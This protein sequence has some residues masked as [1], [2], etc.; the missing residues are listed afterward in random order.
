MFMFRLE[1]PAHWSDEAVDLMVSWLNDKD[2]MKYSEQR[3]QSHSH[4]SQRRYLK[5]IVARDDRFWGIYVDNALVGTVSASMD[6]PN[7][8]ANLGILRGARRGEGIGAFAWLAAT[9][10]LFNQHGIRKIEA[11]MMA[12]NEPMVKTCLRS[13]MAEEARIKEHYEWNGQRMDMVLMG[14][15]Q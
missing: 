5:R 2:L 7:K 8:R 9:T 13:G 6:W 15:R 10:M 14:L 11:G 12:A 4:D 1:A 3:R